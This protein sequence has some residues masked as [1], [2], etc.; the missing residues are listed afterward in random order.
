ML[1]LAYKF[2]ETASFVK[3]QVFSVFLQF[4]IHRWYNFPCS[5][6]WSFLLFQMLL[7]FVLFAVHRLF[8]SI[9]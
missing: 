5:K 3:G 6:R 1:L 4:L 2:L 9:I 8:L 7:A